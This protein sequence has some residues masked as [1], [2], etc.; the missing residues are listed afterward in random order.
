MYSLNNEDKKAIECLDI[1]IG[2]NPIESFYYLNKGR[3]LLNLKKHAQAIQVLDICLLLDKKNADA[4]LYR[5]I[6]V[7]FY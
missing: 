6:C 4:F 2:I 7:I 3:C 5:G 1:C